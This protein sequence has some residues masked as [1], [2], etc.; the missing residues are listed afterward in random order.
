MAGNRHVGGEVTYSLERS[1]IGT[2][3]EPEYDDTDMTPEE[4][5]SRMDQARPTDVSGVAVVGSFIIYA[6]DPIVR[7]GSTGVTRSEQVRF[8]RDQT[9]RGTL[10][11]A[12]T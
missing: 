5:E 1:T 2:M 10:E 3:S 7:T 9:I 4:F 11:L 6:P 8:A 12:G